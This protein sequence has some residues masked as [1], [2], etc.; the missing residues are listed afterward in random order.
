M[1]TRQ[2]GN[3]KNEVSLL[4]FGCMRLPTLPDGAIDEETALAMVR[5]A[6]DS[7][8]NYLDTAYTYHGGK[9][10]EF[11]GKVIQNGYGEKVHIATKMP[12]WLLESPRDCERLFNEQLKRLGVERVDYYLLHALGRDSWHKAVQCEALEFLE[13]AHSKGLI[14]NAGFS[15]HDD[16]AVFRDIVDAYPWDV[17]QIQFNYMDECYQ[18][19]LAGLKYAASKGLGVII[20]EPLRGGRLVNNLPPELEEL[21]ADAPIQRTP[22]E[23]AFR[24]VANHPEV[25]LILSGMSRLEEVE[26]NVRTMVRAT[27]NSLTKKELDLIRKAK[28]IY[29]QRVKVLCTNCK[30]CL[31]CPQDVAI[32]RIFELYNEAHIYNS[33]DGGRWQYGQLLKRGQDAGRCV[34]C[35]QCE[36]LCPQN[37]AIIES[38]EVAHGAFRPEA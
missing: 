7:G 20:M 30:Y 12:V 27:P 5:Y 32:P 6:I 24:W 15:F 3:T 11:V 18:A 22:A 34:A 1:Q 35:G 8:V 38:L 21:F 37:I 25:S 13:N 14:G 23:W 4:G 19:G 2:M 26:E 16:L 28:E 10:E 17:C 29:A 9:S 33:F 36:T 31:P